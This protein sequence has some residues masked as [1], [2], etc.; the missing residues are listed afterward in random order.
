MQVDQEYESEK[1][2]AI[3]D[4]E[5]KKV[6]LKENL[7]AELQVKNQIRGQPKG[8]PAAVLILLDCG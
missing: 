4:F 7:I 5:E 6:E 3:S 1:Q 2:A 8:F